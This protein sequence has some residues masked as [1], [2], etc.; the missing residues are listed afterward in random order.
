MTLVEAPRI[1]IINVKL[2]SK[3]GTGVSL[4]CLFDEKKIDLGQET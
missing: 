3:L 1:C 2:I 4:Y